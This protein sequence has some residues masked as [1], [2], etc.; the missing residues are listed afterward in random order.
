MVNVSEFD[1]P[2]AVRYL[3]KL[4]VPY[5]IICHYDRSSWWCPMCNRRCELGSNVRRWKSILKHKSQGK[6]QRWGK[7]CVDDGSQTEQ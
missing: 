6:S 2:G 3:P 1:S 7:G 5:T 4:Y